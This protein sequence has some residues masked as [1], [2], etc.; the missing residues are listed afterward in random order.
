MLFQPERTS[1][2]PKNRYK[3][4]RSNIPT[5]GDKTG[6]IYHLDSGGVNAIKSSAGRYD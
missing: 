3:A 2:N 4:S 5:Q 1:Y 6:I